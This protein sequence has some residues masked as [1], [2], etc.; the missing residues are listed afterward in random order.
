MTLDLDKDEEKRLK[1]LTN[2]NDKRGYKTTHVIFKKIK[3]DKDHRVK[4]IGIN[5]K[6][7]RIQSIMLYKHATSF[8][9][10]Y[11]HNKTINEIRK[12]E[13]QK[14]KRPITRAEA[15]E[16]YNNRLKYIEEKQIKNIMVQKSLNKR[17]AVDFRNDLIRK[18]NRQALDSYSY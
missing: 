12:E 4:F 3:D 15:K 17:Q 5:R 16:E 8:F 1:R 11:R 7:G 2:M 10:M 18:G 6:T 13:E 14:Q 9:K